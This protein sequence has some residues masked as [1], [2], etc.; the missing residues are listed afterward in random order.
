MQV[1]AARAG[2]NYSLA[3]INFHGAI[4][5]FVVVAQAAGECFQNILNSREDVLPA[6]GGGVLEIEHDARGAG[7]QHLHDEFGVVRRAGHLIAL[8]G[9]PL[10][11]RDAPFRGGGFGGREII[12]IAAGMRGG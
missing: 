2:E 12:G 8:I 9:A 7:I 5:L 6:I 1:Q 11:E 4:A 3:G 10:G